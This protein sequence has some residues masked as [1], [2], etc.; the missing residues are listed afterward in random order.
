MSRLNYIVQIIHFISQ[1]TTTRRDCLS[2][3]AS[4]IKP[5]LQ[6]ELVMMLQSELVMMLQSELVMMLQSELV[7]MLQSEL[8]M[9]LQSGWIRSDVEVNVI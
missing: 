8:V 9:M 2:E 5:V 7:M 6:S 3:S 1:L 4:H